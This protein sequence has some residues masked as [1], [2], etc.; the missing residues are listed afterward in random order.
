MK[1]TVV[2]RA[3]SAAVILF[4][5]AS[6]LPAQNAVASQPVAS[7]VPAATSQPLDSSKIPDPHSKPDIV[8]VVRSPLNPLSPVLVAFGAVASIVGLCVTVSTVPRRT[9]DEGAY[10]GGLYTGLG[11]SFGGA[12]LLL[13]GFVVGN[14]DMHYEQVPPEN[15]TSNVSAPSPTPEVRATPAPSA[16][17]SAGVAPSPR[18]SLESAPQASPLP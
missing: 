8:P 4:M 9:S 5:S 17:V 11:L 1:V 2:R 3:V 14:G 16:S 12:V 18:P 15:R 7:P 10:Y 6:L 13:T